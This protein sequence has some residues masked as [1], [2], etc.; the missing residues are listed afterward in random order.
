MYDDTLHA[1]ECVADVTI[2][3]GSGTRIIEDTSRVH[4]EEEITGDFERFHD[5]RLIC[6]MNTL[7][8]ERCYLWL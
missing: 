7:D 1:S 3:R 6:C 5:G 2:L 4:T 8:M